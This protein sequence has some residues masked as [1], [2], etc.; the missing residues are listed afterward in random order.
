MTNLCLMCFS[1]S[2][3]VLYLINCNVTRKCILSK[4]IS[5]SIGSY[6][7]IIDMAYK[8]KKHESLII[9]FSFTMQQVFLK[10]NGCDRKSQQNGYK[11][12]VI[13]RTFITQT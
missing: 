13:P 12:I 5:A 4:D 11:C 8:C 9:T 10:K 3:N 2:S 6:V 7:I 1:L